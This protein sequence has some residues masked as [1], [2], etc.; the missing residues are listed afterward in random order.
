MKL[1]TASLVYGAYTVIN[2]LSCVAA[3]LFIVVLVL[4][5]QFL[6]HD[7]NLIYF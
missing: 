5:Y 1:A 3:Q 2:S 6:S 4:F 7:L